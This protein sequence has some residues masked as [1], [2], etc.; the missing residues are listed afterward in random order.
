MGALEDCQLMQTR[1][2]L[3]DIKKEVDNEVNY[4]RNSCSKIACFRNIPPTIAMHSLNSE[5]MCFA[6]F[7]S[8][9]IS[10]GWVQ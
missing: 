1:Q 2:L 7:A 4:F 5:H 10:G 8:H 3:F 9:D 6:A